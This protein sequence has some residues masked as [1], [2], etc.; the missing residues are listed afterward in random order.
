MSEDHGPRFGIKLQKLLARKFLLISILVHV[1][2]GFGA[3]YLVVQQ[4]QA[5]RKLT[6]AAGPPVVNASSRALEHK[7]SMAKKKTTMSA[8]AQARR[9][10]TTGLARVALPE[11]PAMPNAMEVIPN[12]MG[13]LGGPGTGYGAGGGGTGMGGGGG[14]GMSVPKIMSDR[15]SPIG[16]RQAM[17]SNG[18]D[19]QNEEAILKGLRWLKQNQSADGSF[20]AQFKASMTGLALL[21]FLG[22]CERPS[23]PEFG[24]CV[25]KAID[26]LLS[27]GE[28]GKL[29]AIGG[30]A[31][32]Y[33]HGI[34][35]YALGEAHILTKDPRIAPVLEKA[36]KIIVDGQGAD[37]GWMYAFSRAIPSDTSVSGWQIQALKAAQ[38]TGLKFE[39]IEGTMSKA[40]TNIMRV[41]GKKG[42]FGYRNAED[43]WSLT[44]VG[45][46]ALEMGKGE[47]GLPVRQGLNFIVEDEKAPPIVYKDTG[48]NL[49][50][51]Y[52]HTQACFQHGG[53]AW[54]KWNRRFQ[55]EIRTSQ[56]ED[57]SWPETGSKAGE[58]KATFHHTGTGTSMD[59]QV[60][61]TS[62]CILMLEVYYRYLASSKV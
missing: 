32:A 51:W 62:L 52:Y 37:G 35:T 24:E 55:K 45:V 2:F 19:P 53:S 60:Y 31:W 43:R 18:G 47:R 27:L 12:K 29:S 14:F 8:P 4:I 1:F 3:A 34:A 7:V 13:G 21:S 22:H 26:Y 25:K 58:K 41:R 40:M 48:C 17:T 9:I 30:N 38:L 57:G 46:L 50:A 59:A 36:V 61:R 15:C 6:F 10:T 44:G 49:Y 54:T 33:E 23:S 5:K 56:S 11:M 20:G 28:D 42:G 16:R 39:G